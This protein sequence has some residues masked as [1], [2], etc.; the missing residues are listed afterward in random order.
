MSKNNYMSTNKYEG[1]TINDIVFEGRNKEYGA[2][3]IRRTHPRNMAISIGISISVFVIFILFSSQNISIGKT[4]DPK[5][6]IVC[7]LEMPEIDPSIPIPTPQPISPPSSPLPNLAPQIAFVEM[8]PT[9]DPL[10]DN[11]D[12]ATQQ[13][14][15][16]TNST[17]GD[18]NLDGDPNAR[19]P[20]V[21]PQ[22]T[23][24]GS[25]PILPKDPEPAPIENEVF[26]NVQEMPEFPGGKVALMKYL[27]AVTYPEIAL[28]NGMEGTVVVEFIIEKDG[29]VSNVKVI[30]GPYN[31]LNEAA[32][33]HIKKMPKWKPGKQRENPA[34]VKMVSPM[35][36]KFKNR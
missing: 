19:A 28:E 2:Y 10:E 34:R 1:L 36:F 14:L 20:I 8:R 9:N 25:G 21:N 4:K 17:I 18:Q 29:S 15:L 24:Y 27:T 5:D 16:A 33:Q 26:I 31:V 3:E 23:N 13:Q 32:M 6:V 7:I 12:I 11:N 35:N 22:P 30:K